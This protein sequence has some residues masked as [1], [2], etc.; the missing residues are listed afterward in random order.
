MSKAGYEIPDF[1]YKILTL[2]EIEFRIEKVTHVSGAEITKK[3]ALIKRQKYL[4]T[5]RFWT[6]V[7]AIYGFGPSIFTFFTEEEVFNRILERINQGKLGKSPQ[8]Q[9]AVQKSPDSEQSSTLLGA[10]N[11]GKE[12][13]SADQ[14]A[15]ILEN[16][17]ANPYE[18]QYAHGVVYSRHKLRRPIEFDIGGDIFKACFSLETPLD[19][20]GRPSIFVSMTRVASNT[21]FVA[22][23]K[24]FKTGIILG[25]HPVE[26]LERAV[27]AYSNED[28][29]IGFKD[30]L[31]TAQKS[32]ASVYEC[33]QLAKTIYRIPNAAYKNTFRTQM[34]ETDTQNQ[35]ACRNHLIELLGRLSGDLRHIYGVSNLDSISEKKMKTIPAKCSVYDLLCVVSQITSL[36][37]TPEGA[38]PLLQWMGQ[39]IAVEFDLELSRK[40]VK[41]FE[42]F[43]DPKAQALAMEEATNIGQYGKRMLEFK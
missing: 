7:C 27:D 34:G 25:K 10:C 41:V 21:T 20:Y 31:V 9:V 2:D 13:I 24:L 15:M 17:E 6:S 4:P 38:G 3:I 11:P 32:W 8:M 36:Q 35:Y 19:G 22:Y 12:Y 1:D 33:A 43:L 26:T 14:C 18:T 29:Y 37:V 28:G 40:E 30:R 39:T 16:S 23:H 42:A 5:S